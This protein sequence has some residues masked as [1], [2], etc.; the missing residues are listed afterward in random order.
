MKRKAILEAARTLFVHKGY[1]ETTIAEIAQAAGVAVGTI[2]LYFRNKHEI[3]VAAS[4]DLEESLI[5]V[6]TDPALFDL[7]F[8]QVPR[9]LMEAVFRIGR[10]KKEHMH[11]LKIAV[12]S[13]LEILQQKDMDAQLTGAIDAFLRNAIA[14]GYLAPFN[15]E[16][17]GQMIYLL[18]Q[19]VLH[20]CFAIEKGEREELYLQ[21]AIELLERLFYG[22]SLREG[23]PE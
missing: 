18:G 19:A 23:R 22:P 6:F 14:R 7:P 3:L 9:A 17:Y 8:E 20:Q 5:Q 16:M 15:T 21:Y 12:P 4:L 1:E 10:H 13:S 2:Y 11:L